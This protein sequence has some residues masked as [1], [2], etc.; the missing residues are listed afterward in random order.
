MIDSSNNDQGALKQLALLNRIALLAVQ[1]IDESQSM[2]QCIVETLQKE[3]NWEFVSCVVIDKSTNEFV[4]QAASST[5]P[6]D[7]KIGYRRVLGTGVVGDCVIS[8]QTIELDDT[9]LSRLCRHTGRDPF[10][11]VRSGYTQQ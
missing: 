8:G 5:I 9:G 6:S 2:L 11:A 10:R 3:F 1:D 4:C 7:V